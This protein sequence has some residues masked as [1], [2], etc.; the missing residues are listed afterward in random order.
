MDPQPR[1]GLTT[2]T[3]RPHDVHRCPNPNPSR[4]PRQQKTPIALQA[5]AAPRTELRGGALV[6][7]RHRRKRGIMRNTRHTSAGMLL[8]L[9][10]LLSGC[11]SDGSK[12]VTDLVHRGTV[13]VETM[14]SQ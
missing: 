9:S 14:P 4:H 6:R 7:I 3:A 13:R 12:K 10:A 8:L 11:S 5:T 2:V 1:T